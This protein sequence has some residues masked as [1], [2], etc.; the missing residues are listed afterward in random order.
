MLRWALVM[1]MAAVLPACGG[2]G[3]DDDDDCTPTTCEAASANCGDMP[4][5][6]GGQV[7]C[8]D[9]T[10]PEMCGGGGANVCGTAACGPTTCV[11]E[12]ANCGLISDGCS[13]VLS[14]GTCTSPEI[15]GG[16][17][18][19]NVCAAPPDPD[20]PDAP[21][22]T[23]GECSNECMNQSGA[24]CCRA[25]GCSAEVRCNPVCHDPYQWDCE[26]LC[27]FEYA[28]AYACEGE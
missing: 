25:C 6:C 11:I 3:G 28:P 9:C 21:R 7:A 2:S 10:A 4:D 5:G 20:E 16:G 22:T 15:C 24:V 14:C 8:G 12:G 19:P 13:T 1:M 26:T 18:T 17:D 27:C 23:S